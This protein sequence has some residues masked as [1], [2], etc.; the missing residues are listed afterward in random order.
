MQMLDDLNEARDYTEKSKELLF[1][2]GS[3]LDDFKIQNSGG[4]IVQNI[5][6]MQDLISS[7]IDEAISMIS[8]KSG[9]TKYGV[10]PDFMQ[11]SNEI[12]IDDDEDIEEIIELD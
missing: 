2:V 6:Q 10:P 4:R 3:M 9:M 7:C 1:E 5:V 8:E 12:D 11:S